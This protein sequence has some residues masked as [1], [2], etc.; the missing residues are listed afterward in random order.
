MGR[1]ATAPQVSAPSAFHGPAGKIPAVTFKIVQPLEAD[2][3]DAR[4][5]EALEALAELYSLA[6]HG[7]G[8]EFIIDSDTGEPVTLAELRKLAALDC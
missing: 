7:C 8:P 5:L 2:A 1:L 4:V 3:P 6:R